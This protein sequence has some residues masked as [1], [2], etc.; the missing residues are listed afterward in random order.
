MTL[1]NIAVSI[2]LARD[3]FARCGLTSAFESVRALE[4]WKTSDLALAR[5][6][7]IRQQSP[8]A[9]AERARLT[10]L[11]A[12]DQYLAMSPRAQRRAAA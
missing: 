12:I 2:E 1:D 7:L 8:V 9:S 4:V 5:D 10:A 3:E 11:R 6:T